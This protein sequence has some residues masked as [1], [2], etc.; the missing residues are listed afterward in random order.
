MV[1]RLVRLCVT[2][3][4]TLALAGV[5]LVTGPIQPTEAATHCSLTGM[6]HV[7]TKKYKR[8]EIRI[9]KRVTDNG[10][11]FVCT[12]AY[13]KSGKS[14]KDKMTIRYGN[15]GYY[16]S[17]STKGSKLSHAYYA[18]S[19]VCVKVK[20]WRKGQSYTREVC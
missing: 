7:K 11:K 6:H 17:R 14:E 8:L 13:K 2:L 15:P 12:K 4:C 3:A 19:G 10:G 5:W 20:V 16:D 9:Y 18:P 1:S